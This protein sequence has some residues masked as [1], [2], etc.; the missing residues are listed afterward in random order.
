MQKEKTLL[1]SDEEKQKEKNAIIIGFGLIF[2]VIIFT[3]ARNTIFSSST[4]QES[5]KKSFQSQ[6]ED[7]FP[8]KTISSKELNKKIIGSNKKDGLTLLDVRSFDNYIQEHIVDAIN[9]PLD[10]F[11]VGSKIDSHNLIIIIGTNSQDKDVKTA[12]EKLK[13][14]NFENILVL[15]GG[16]DSWKQLIGATVTYGNPKSFVDQSKVSYLDPEQLNDA[17]SQ[18][19]PVYIIDVRSTENFAKGHI[20]GAKNIPFEELEKRRLEIT[21]KKIVVV[22]ENE[23]QEFQAGV[24]MYDMLLASPYIMRTAMPGWQNK[25]FALIK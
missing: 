23:L 22:G 11:P 12:I 18:Q 4:D 8:Y 21:E 24:Q 20:A 16:M 19:V 25:G 15:A 13:Q 5:D 2:F 1:Q 17:L 3:I 6:F 10:E 14:D 7:T 9:I